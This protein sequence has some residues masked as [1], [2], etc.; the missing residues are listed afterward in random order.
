MVLRERAARG[1]S[2]GTTLSRLL[3]LF[4]CVVTMVALWGR[5][6]FGRRVVV[7]LRRWEPRVAWGG[8][9]IF[10][11][12]VALGAASSVPS[13]CGLCHSSQREAM[14][15]SAHATATCYDCHLPD[16]WSLPERKLSELFGMYPRRILSGDT[17]ISSRIADG[18]CRRCH[19]QSRDGISRGG[20]LVVNH[21]E[22]IVENRCVDCHGSVSHPDAVRWAR[23]PS[24]DD[25]VA[26]HVDSGV[27][28]D[29]E[30]CHEGR[31]REDLQQPGG[32][33]VTHGPAWEQTHG[34]G[35]LGA[36]AACH[37]EDKCISC[38]GTVIPHGEDVIRSH[39]EDAT[40]GEDACFVCHARSF[41]DE[42]HGLEMPHPDSFLPSHSELV[43]A[44]GTNV[45]ATCHR[46]YDCTN[47]HVR[48]THPGTTDGWLGGDADG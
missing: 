21:V 45:C 2:G 9:T 12:L 43:G 46:K 34:M 33:G 13:V 4:R 5:T 44:D 41:C 48:H 11:V 38:H 30:L 14:A 28:S 6:S 29:C 36:C 18:A 20:G 8:A 25:C 10:L 3:I 31:L 32:F 40:D 23:S 47:C 42:C 26:C 35:N 24:M 22:C 15:Q 1:D 17:Q 7:L 16:V 19:D 39:G 37:P 27:P